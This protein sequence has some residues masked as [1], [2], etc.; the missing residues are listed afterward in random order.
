[1]A[2]AC[3]FCDE[4]CKKKATATQLIEG[5]RDKEVVREVLKAKKLTMEDAVKI[6]N[7]YQHSK[8]E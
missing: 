1:M 3:E 4:D 7:S 8:T 5:T 6:V 2:A